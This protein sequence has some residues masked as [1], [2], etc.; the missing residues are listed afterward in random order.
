MGRTT[1]SSRAPGAFPRDATHDRF[2]FESNPLPMWIIDRETLK[3][4][5]VNDAAVQHYG[6]SRE[7]FLAR[8][9]SDV[10][11]RSERARL[12]A[13]VAAAPDGYYEGGTWTHRRKDGSEISVEVLSHTLR[14]EGR[15]ARIAVCIDVTERLRVNDGLRRSIEALEALSARLAK[16][17]NRQTRRV[18][19]EIHDEVR[20]ALTSLKIELAEYQP[21][22]S[23]ALGPAGEKRFGADPRAG[24]QPHDALSDRELEVFRLFARGK[25]LTAIARQLSLA[26]QTVS[27]YRARISDK[28]GLQS[29][30]EM[31]RYA[32]GN[33][34]LD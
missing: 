20:Q 26:V 9:A 29:R 5:A 14:F 32:I 10:R 28:T 22:V 30:E 6:Y 18:A 34:L 19:K 16:T 1:R 17:R 15:A 12:R 13:A 4:L 2:L 23:G 8:T 27:T 7:E 25:T 24:S 33:R 11:P 3:F 21:G 31:T